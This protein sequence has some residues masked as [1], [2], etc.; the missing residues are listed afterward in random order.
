MSFGQD[1]VDGQ[2]E[3]WQGASAKNREMYGTGPRDPAR[4]AIDVLDRASI[5]LCSLKD[6]RT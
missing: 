1:A 6:L 4:F 2:R 3:H 5:D